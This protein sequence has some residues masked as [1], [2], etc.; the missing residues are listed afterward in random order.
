MGNG[1]RVTE[2]GARYL[3]VRATS[4][5]NGGSTLKTTSLKME[6]S[7]AL[8][9]ESVGPARAPR[10]PAR[11][12]SSL[13]RPVRVHDSFPRPEIGNTYG[14]DRSRLG[15]GCETAE[16]AWP[17]RPGLGLDEVLELALPQR[18][19]GSRMAKD[20][21]RFKDTER[22]L[23]VLSISNVDQEIR[24]NVKRCSVM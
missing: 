13:A 15:Y 17:M 8:T 11:K 5:T 10:T 7:F 3:Q 16:T 23:K 2:I 22:L 4:R 6:E 14:V 1:C 18:K 21:Q 20:G 19:A 24:Y 12:R 9:E